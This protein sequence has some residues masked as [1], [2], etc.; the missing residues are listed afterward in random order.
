MS[1]GHFL[2]PCKHLFLP[3]Q[4]VCQKSFNLLPLSPAKVPFI[5]WHLQNCMV[6]VGLSSITESGKEVTTVQLPGCPG[7][8]L[9]PQWSHLQHEPHWGACGGSVG[10]ESLW[11]TVH[12][13]EPRYTRRWSLINTA[14]HRQD[15]PILRVML[16][17]VAG[18]L[19]FPPVY[20]HCFQIFSSWGAV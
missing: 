9:T 20:T 4:Q 3:L 10:C 13:S 6:G 11:L 18:T 1:G 15:V 7:K 17:K 2:H 19:T 14:C 8:T 5:S 12:G 16:G